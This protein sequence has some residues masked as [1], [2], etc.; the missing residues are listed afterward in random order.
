MRIV[1]KNIQNIQNE[2]LVKLF[3]RWNKSLFS[4]HFSSCTHKKENEFT[5]VYTKKT[6]VSLAKLTSTFTDEKL[7]RA[8]TYSIF[9]YFRFWLKLEKTNA[10]EKR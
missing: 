2:A 1:C 7:L 10:T 9:F 6:W 3:R 4:F 5:G 8:C